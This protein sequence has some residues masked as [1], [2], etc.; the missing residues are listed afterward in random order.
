[1]TGLN[2][3]TGG[4]EERAENDTDDDF[5]TDRLFPLKTWEWHDGSRE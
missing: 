1:M 3:Y 5:V 4:G 2:P